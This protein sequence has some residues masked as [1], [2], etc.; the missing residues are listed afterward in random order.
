MQIVLYLT[1]GLVILGISGSLA[2]FVNKKTDNGLLTA[3]VWFGS[4]Y[5]LLELLLLAAARLHP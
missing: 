1:F 5:L 2:A 3:L 4:A